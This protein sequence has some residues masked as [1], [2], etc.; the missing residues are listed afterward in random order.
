MKN[1]KGRDGIDDSISSKKDMFVLMI[2]CS[3]VIEI[4]SVELEQIELVQL[5][6]STEI[7]MILRSRNV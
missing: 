5:I 3:R 6:L 4:R 2:A 7:T 1:E